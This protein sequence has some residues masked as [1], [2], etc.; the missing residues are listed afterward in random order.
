MKRPKFEPV[1]ILPTLIARA[2][3]AALG[4]PRLPVAVVYRRVP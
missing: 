2:V 4:L 3:R 1:Y